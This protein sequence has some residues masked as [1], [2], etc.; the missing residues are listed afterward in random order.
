MAQDDSLA[1]L[2]TFPDLA[3]L[4][5]AAKAKLKQFARIV[6]APIGTI[7]YREA[8][9]C[10]AYVMRLTGRSRVYKISE[11]GR[12]IVLYRVGAGGTCV[13]TTTCLLGR[14]HYPAS[15]VVEE[16]VRDVVI[17]AATFHQLMVE[18][19]VF[20]RFVLSNYGDLISD[21]IVLVDEV[22]FHSIASRLAGLLVTRQGNLTAT[23]QQLADELGSARE[24]VSRELKVFEN[25]GWVKLGRASIEVLDRAALQAQARG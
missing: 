9:P 8:D 10:N 4:D 7:G 18:S 24:V 25:Q 5:E 20:R 3:K 19:E 23:H 2:S 11:S 14:S 16:P 15:T 12:E 22:A 6:E 1:W 21:L 13:L 17:P